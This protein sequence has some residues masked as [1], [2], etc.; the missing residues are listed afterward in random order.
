MSNWIALSFGKHEG[1]T[2]PQVLFKDPDWF[3]WSVNKGVFK[4]SNARIKAEVKEVYEKATHVK[5]P[6]AGMKVEY[7]FNYANGIL[8]TVRLVPDNYDGYVG[9]HSFIIRTYLDFSIARSFKSYDKLGNKILVRACKRILFGTPSA[10]L[11]KKRCE[12]FF[13]NDTNFLIKVSRDVDLF[14]NVIFD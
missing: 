14:G 12:E 11:T 6:Y 8:E 3:F 10:R 7:I 9:G 1:L 5:I 4:K 2:L 13:N